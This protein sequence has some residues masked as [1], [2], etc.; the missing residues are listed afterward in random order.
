[1]YS[2]HDYPHEVYPQPWFSDP[3]YPANLPGHWDGNWGYLFKQ[4]IAPVLLGEFGTRLADDSDR[5]WLSTLT[6]YLRG[7]AQYGAD[8]ISWMFWSWNPNSGDTGGILNDDWTT[9]N[10]VKDGYLDAIKRPFT[11]GPVP[12]PSP[13]PTPTP[14]P[15][16]SPS[17]LRVLYRNYDSNPRDNQVKPGLQVVNRGTTSVSLSRV[18]LRYWFTRDGGSTTVNTWC[19]WAQ[20]GCGAITRAVGDGYLQVGFTGG[21]LAPGAATG[22]I[23]LRFSKADWSPFDE[24]NDASYGTNRTYAETDK[25]TITVN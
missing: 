10:Q 5:K 14:T 2:P 20:I 24:T 3:S 9:V 6:G 17:S 11:G 4:G 23:Q 19:D 12:T 1:V 15:P 7:S 16:P 21:T 25:I 8:S 22:D 18:K 13:T